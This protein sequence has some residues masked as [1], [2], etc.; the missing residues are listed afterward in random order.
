[1]IE[2]I[3]HPE[4]RSLVSSSLPFIWFYPRLLKE[5]V[6]DIQ[7]SWIYVSNTSQKLRPFQQG[8]QP[9]ALGVEG[10]KINQVDYTIKVAHQH[11]PSEVNQNCKI[12]AHSNNKLFSLYLTFKLSRS[13]I[14]MVFSSN[15]FLLDVIRDLFIKCQLERKQC[16]LISFIKGSSGEYQEGINRI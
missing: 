11:N 6:W 8:V 13:D 14:W 16:H 1:M 10:Y 3:F 4:R 2:M 5:I 7:F 12:H 9:G 15:P